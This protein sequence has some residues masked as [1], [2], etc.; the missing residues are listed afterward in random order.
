MIDNS[1]SKDP[2]INI[3]SLNM[4]FWDEERWVNIVNRVSFEIYPGETLGLV[5]ESGCGKT[6]TAGA[7]M[8]YKRSGTRIRSGRISFQGNNILELNDYELKKMRGVEISMV[9]QNPGMALT[10]TMRVGNQASEI[11]KVHS[12]YIKGEKERLISLFHHVGLP[13]PLEIYRRYPHQL[14]GGQQQRIVIAMALSCNPKLVLLDEPTTALDVTT[15]AQ[16]LNLLIKLRAEH[17][18]SMLYVTHNLG[19]IAQIA[20]RIAVM[21]AGELI[22]IAPTKVIFE[23]PYHPYTKGLIDAVPKIEAIERGESKLRGILKRNEIAKGCRFA[24]RC[25]YAA[26]KCY[27]EYQNL[28][29]VAPDHEVACQFWQDI[30]MD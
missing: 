6:T 10:P 7:M 21:Y 11:L 29:K 28:I 12:K 1:T 23:N 15:Q 20:D 24:P 19:V 17:D 27:E 2:L 30:I 16:I 13:Q 25:N 9:P 4:D 5:G 14:S 18:M 22:E 8:S 3:Q 26:T